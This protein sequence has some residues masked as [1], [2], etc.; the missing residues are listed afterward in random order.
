MKNFKLLVLA[1]LAFNLVTV[2]C[3]SDDDNG[4]N[5]ETMTINGEQF[6]IAS[7]FLTEFG[8]NSDGSYDWDVTLFS[9]GFTINPTQQSASGEGASIYLDLNT[10]SATGLVPG[11]YTF[12]DDREEFTW[13][14]AEG[15]TNL[16]A[17]TGDGDFFVAESG[18]VV[19]TGTGNDQVIEVNLVDENGNALTAFY[20]GSLQ[21]F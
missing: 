19:I 12:S 16:N 9:E 11:T 1:V 10:N 2:S 20:S 17:E 3:K 6:S 5:S 21:V 14:D 18:T 4:G 7:G 15:V 13:V 8:E